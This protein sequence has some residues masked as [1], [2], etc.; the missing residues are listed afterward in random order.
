MKESFKKYGFFYLF[1]V[2]LIFIIGIFLFNQSYKK[3]FLTFVMLDVGQGD[4]L[5]VETS[6]GTQILIDSGR[7]KTVLRELNKVMPFWDRSIDILIITNPDLD[8][9]GGFLDVLD[10]YE[11]KYIFEPGTYNDSSIYK[12]IENKI[13]E[14]NV[15]RLLGK[16]PL[17]LDIGDETYLEFLFPDRDVS[18]WDNNDGSM[19]AMLKYGVN[20]IMLTG[21]AT[22]ETEKIILEKYSQ[23]YLQ[24]YILKAGHHGSNT[25]TSREFLNVLKPKYALISSGKGNK[26]GHPHKE[27]LENLKDFNVEILRTDL[28]GTIVFECAKMSL[29]DLK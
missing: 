14:K 26:Y 17:K 12:N 5:F 20:K 18:T 16:Y 28:L 19:V 1:L 29:C 7:D 6:I 27:V 22:I 21:D 2:L 15:K 23:E 10:K 4:A 13:K 25:S 3:D 8:H 11:V 9:I 24:S